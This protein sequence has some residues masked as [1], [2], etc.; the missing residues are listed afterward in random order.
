MSA[1][2]RA[3][4]YALISEGVNWLTLARARIGY[5]NTVSRARIGLQKW[6]LN[7]CRYMGI[8]SILGYRPKSMGSSKSA[9]GDAWGPALRPGG[10]ALLTVTTASAS[11]D[12]LSRSVPSLAT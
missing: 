6:R 10:R 2:W 1:P 3:G 7:P 5:K 4:G 8:L 12:Q 9:W 11:K